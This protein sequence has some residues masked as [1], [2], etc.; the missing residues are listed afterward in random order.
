MVSPTPIDQ[1]QPSPTQQQP[2]AH[3]QFLPTERG[4]VMI[5][6][7]GNNL[8]FTQQYMNLDM[9]YL[10]LVE[11]L[12]GSAKLV[13]VMF[14]AGVDTQSSQSSN[15]QY[16]MRRKG[17]KMVTKPLM[18]LPDGS[19]KANCDVEMAVDMVMMQDAFDTAI[20]LSGDSD[21][22][23]AV[24]RLSSEGKQVEIVGSRQ[25][26]SIALTDAADRFVDL[27]GLRHQIAKR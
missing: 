4:R 26:T 10:K 16:F 14:Y 2:S 15:W 3:Q 5:F 27:E 19:K 25:N 22:T 18:T 12:V 24:Q 7:D 9:D 23:Y 6:I 13:R 21:L 11:V 1:Q 20:V 17:F 8:F